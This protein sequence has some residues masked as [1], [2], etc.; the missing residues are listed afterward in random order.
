V[1][2]KYLEDNSMNFSTT[3]YK[4]CEVL[5]TAGRIDG[6]TAPELEVALKAIIDAGKHNIIFDMTEVNFL[7]SAGWWVLIGTQKECKKL[8]RGELVLACVDQTIRNSLNLVGMEEY[9]KIFDD[10]TKAVGSF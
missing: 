7:S 10:V 8:S 1:D 3:S 5:K 2:A 9:F 4:R 6:S